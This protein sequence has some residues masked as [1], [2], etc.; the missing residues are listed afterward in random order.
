MPLNW[1]LSKHR[2]HNIIAEVDGDIMYT[3]FRTKRN[4]FSWCV[5]SG[6]MM[7]WYVNTFFATQREA[8]DSAEG[9]HA[10]IQ[11]VTIEDDTTAQAPLL[12]V[13]SD[14]VTSAFEDLP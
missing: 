6:E 3:V 11:P 5:K 2:N 14:A 1:K 4:T 9:F 10:D 12:L 7:P 8:I 13:A